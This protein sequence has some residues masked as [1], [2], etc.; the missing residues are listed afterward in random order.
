[1]ISRPQPRRTKQPHGYRAGPPGGIGLGWWLRVV[2]FALVLAANAN[3][4]I[5]VTDDLG[6]VIRLVQPARR[7]V[8][9]APHVTELLFA[10]GAGEHVIAVVDHSDFP[11]AARDLTR[12]GSSK[13]VSHESLVA[14]RPDLI[15]AWH[16]GNGPD[17]INRVRELGLVVYVNEPRTL[18]DVASALRDLGRLSGHETTSTAAADAFMFRYRQLYE[19]YQARPPVTVFYQVWDQPLTT[20]NGRHLI[21]D[22]IRLCGGRNVF[23]DAIPI[24]PKVSIEAVIRANPH[25]IVASGM[26]E[27]RPDWL[28]M[29]QAWPSI[30]AVAAGQ[31][32][33]VPP[34]LLQRHTPRVLDGAQM[35]C[36]QLDRTRA[37]RPH[38]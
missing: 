38:Q 19:R 25:V 15:V 14:M 2:A 32:Y 22:V 13:T 20:L 18:P 28:D 7:I 17:I 33:F 27:S 30:A 21:S 36:E 37:L 3:A 8:S 26:A 6:D 12:L 29:W 1:M 9:L 11:P 4:E 34:D 31:L 23:A 10:A 35:L 16:S 24:A 5:T